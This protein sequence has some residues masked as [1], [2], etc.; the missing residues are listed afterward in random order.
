M[1]ITVIIKRPNEKPFI[2]DV[3]KIDDNIDYKKHLDADLIDFIRVEEGIGCIIHDDFMGES[4]NF[5][6]R[7]HQPIYGACMFVGT[8]KEG[9]ALSLTRRQ[10]DLLVLGM[11]ISGAY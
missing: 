7:E 1:K 6:L 11:Q 4:F 9:S 3:E 10:I 8:D 2:T 5:Y